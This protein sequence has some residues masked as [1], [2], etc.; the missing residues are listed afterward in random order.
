MRLLGPPLRALAQIDDPV[1]VG[2]ILRSLAW[3][4]AAFVALAAAV[5]WGAEAAAAGHRTWAWI[6][7]LAGSIGVAVLA[8][9]LFLPLAAV[10]ATLFVDRVADAVERRFYPGLPPAHPA[11]LAAQTWDGCML[12]LRVLALQVVGLLLALLVPGLGLLLGWLISAWAIGRGLFMVVAMRRMERG[13]ATAAY[14]RARASAVAQGG[15][16]AAAGLVPLLN[17]LVPVLGT[18]AM[19]HVLHGEAR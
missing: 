5:A 3:A 8:V 10:I 18:A 19:V 11:S 15:L 7:G 14:H 12:G 2:V 16:M 17:L 1:F 4:L 6:A 13:A 9:W